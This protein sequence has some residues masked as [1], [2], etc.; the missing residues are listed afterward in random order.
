MKKKV[1]IIS[2]LLIVFFFS[3]YLITSFQGKEITNKDNKKEQTLHKEMGLSKEEFVIN[4][5]IYPR[6]S[7]STESEDVSADLLPKGTVVSVE[8]VSDADN[9]VKIISDPFKGYISRDVL[10]NRNKYI[11]EREAKR[12]NFLS[13]TQFVKE[14]NEQ[15]NS[16]LSAK[17]G[18]ISIYLES[19]DGSLSYSFY[20]DEIKR[21]ASS[22][23]LPFITYLMLLATKKQ[24]A[25]DT[26]LI[27][28]E[29]FKID[30][31][32]IIQFEP[33]GTTYSIDKLAELVIRYSD[34][35]AYLMLLNYVGEQNFINYLHELDNQSPNNRAFS[36]PRIL[37][38]SMKYVVENKTTNPLI[39]KVYKWMEQTIFDDGITVGLPG[40]N[41][42]HKTGWMPMYLVSN[43][44][45]YID[46]KKN[47]YILTIM[48]NGYDEEYSEK[49]LA[50]LAK[51]ID[52][53]MLKLKT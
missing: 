51:I 20:G 47:P 1:G 18:D 16:F 15:L 36:S 34:N 21:T 41:V 2:L 5:D 28:T 33:L 24:I 53:N 42:V 12:S 23:K 8:E 38:K 50:D 22:I 43:D 3:G 7:L 40:V 45:A 19:L 31:T 6:K 17:G 13:S 29:G 37:S 25:L 26:R 39:D 9:L 4:K 35:V 48:T 46:D 10:D 14:T 49:V 52:N 30:G 32:G 27:Y 44:V 11:D